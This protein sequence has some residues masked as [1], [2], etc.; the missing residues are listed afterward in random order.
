MCAVC[1]GNMTQVKLITLH[2]RNILEYE[3]SDVQLLR[4]ILRDFLLVVRED[5][6]YRVYW[7]ISLA[8]HSHMMFINVPIKLFAVRNLK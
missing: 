2:Y 4:R 1:D 7:T 3:L 8:K 6:L 5:H